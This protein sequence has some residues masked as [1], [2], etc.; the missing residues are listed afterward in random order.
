MERTDN[1]NEYESQIRVRL[2]Y[3]RELS[4]LN[5]ERKRQEENEREGNEQ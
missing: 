1:D 5:E 4:K 3:Y 2:A